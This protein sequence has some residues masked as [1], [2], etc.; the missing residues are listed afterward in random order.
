MLPMTNKNLCHI[1]L[2]HDI[3]DLDIL[4]LMP[5]PNHVVICDMKKA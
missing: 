4:I 3:C 5:K 2:K 1:M